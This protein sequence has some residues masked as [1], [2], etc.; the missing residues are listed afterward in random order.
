MT[1]EERFESLERRIRVVVTEL[2][3][4]IGVLEKRLEKKPKTVRP[5]SKLVRDES[6]VV[7]MAFTKDFETFWAATGRGPGRKESAF[8]AYVKRGSPDPARTAFTW[9]AYLAS[10]PA[11]Q[12]DKGAITHVATWLNQGGH[13]D[14][15]APGKVAA[16]GGGR[17]RAPQLR[18]SDD[19]D[20]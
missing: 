17:S 14:D 6:G 8:R 1:P 3:E 5:T 20:R 13:L 11:E 19:L 15:Y 9:K 4:R 12:V 2:R 10:L 16:A 18:D 7:T